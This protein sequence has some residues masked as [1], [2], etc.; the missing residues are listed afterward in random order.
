MTT[1]PDMSGKTVL[2]TGAN[3]GIGKETA[4]AL[5]GMGATVVMTSRDREKGEAA[6]A[7]VASRSG[8]AKVELMIGD[9][10]SLDSIHKLAADVKASHERLDVL[11]NNAGA[12]NA[13]R[14]ETSD[15]FETT[16]GVNHLGYFLLTKLLL[17]TLKAS[18]PSRVVNVSSRAHLRSDVG[19][20][21]SELG[22]RLQRDDGVRTLEA[23]ECAVYV[24]AGA[25]A[26]WD[27]RHSER[28]ASRRRADGVRDEQR[29]VAQI[30]I[31]DIPRNR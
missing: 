23:G 15:G 24:R 14:S 12:Y 6:R 3:N 7:D 17:D 20:R 10:A 13:S 29:R 22:A 18:A 27:G 5:A 25:P 9:F 28:V 2:V 19:L 30:R 16:F 31:R 8:S 21:R 4:A 1:N 26:R 11:V